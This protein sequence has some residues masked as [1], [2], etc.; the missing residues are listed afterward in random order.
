MYLAQD[1]AHAWRALIFPAGNAASKYNQKE[2]DDGKSEDKHISRILS[3]S[4]AASK[5]K[6]KEKYDGKSEENHVS[7]TVR[8]QN[9]LPT[10][11]LPTQHP[12]KA[13]RRLTLREGEAAE[14]RGR[15]ALDSDHEEAQPG[16]C[17]SLEPGPVAAVY[18]V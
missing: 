9:R 11:I 17:P 4:K 1:F 2:K 8:T 15:A 13:Q 7:G 14:K 3:A 16:P 12:A 18:R 5:H 6:Q 10:A